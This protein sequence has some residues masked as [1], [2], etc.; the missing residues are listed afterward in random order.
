MPTPKEINTNVCSSC[1]YMYSKLEI[2]QVFVS[3]GMNKQIVV[4]PYHGMLA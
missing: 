2:A 3:W 4:Y 1:I